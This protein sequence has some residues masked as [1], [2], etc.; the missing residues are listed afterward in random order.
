MGNQK[1]AFMKRLLKYQF[2]FFLILL[3][4][5]MLPAQ[6]PCYDA[7]RTE[8]L[9]FLKQDN[10]KLSINRFI[11]ARFCLDAPAGDDLDSLVSLAQEKWVAEL[12]DAREQAYEA[13][14]EALAAKE[15][16]LASKEQ[17]EKAT[18]EAQEYAKQREEQAILTEANRLALLAENEIKSQNYPDALY[19]AFRA[20]Q[21]SEAHPSPQIKLTFGRAVYHNFTQDVIGQK[22]APT[23]FLALKTKPN[24]AAIFYNKILLLPTD[25]SQKVKE[26]IYPGQ[27]LSNAP[28]ISVVSSPN[29]G[30]ILTCTEDGSALLWS[31]EKE[32]AF[33]LKGHR[34]DVLGG[35]FSPAEDKV[36]T[37]SR[38]HTAKLWNTQGGLLATL[39]GHEGTIYEG[40]FSPDGAYLLARSSSWA[41]RLWNQAGQPAAPPLRHSGYIYSS[42]FSPDG[43]KIVTASADSTAKIWNLNGQLLLALHPH[44]DAVKEALF[45]PRGDRILTR[46]LDRSLRVWRLDGTLLARLPHAGGYPLGAIFNRAGDKIISFTKAAVMVWNAEGALELSLEEHTGPIISAVWSPDETLILSTSKDG[47]AKLWDTEGRLLMSIDIRRQ[48]PV[49]ARFSFD[50]KQL[51]AISREGKLIQCPIPEVSFQELEQELPYTEEELNRLNR[52]YKIAEYLSTK[53]VKEEKPEE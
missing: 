49:P 42:V 13:A 1:N 4:L 12:E 10:Y 23:A 32:Q 28:I 24:L 26:P 2:T 22:E 21:L 53:F 3:G 47:T 9:Q 45:S 6:D 41:V 33:L 30:F 37:W 52:E 19:L 50:G 48:N 34:E 40:H 11:A 7:L 5:S 35:V 16:A 20:S 25:S 27:Q 46:C 43:S 8:G 29:E 44:E 17:A 36:L 18:K 39:S 38:D 31:L 15:I 51:I 14:R